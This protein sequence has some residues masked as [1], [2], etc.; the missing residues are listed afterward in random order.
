MISF[1][2]F[3]LFYNFSV[4]SKCS[5]NSWHSRQEGWQ[6][7]TFSQ[8]HFI[9]YI[10]MSMIYILC[11]MRK[12]K[13]SIIPPLAFF[14]SI[15]RKCK[16]NK[17]KKKPLNEWVWSEVSQSSVLFAHQ[18][19]KYIGLTVQSAAASQP[20][21]VIWSKTG[22]TWA[23]GIFCEFYLIIISS[24]KRDIPEQ[25]TW[26]YVLRFPFG[27]TS[28]PKASS[29]VGRLLRLLP[30]LHHPCRLLPNLGLS[31]LRFDFCW[32]VLQI[33]DSCHIFSSLNFI[34]LWTYFEQDLDHIPPFVLWAVPHRQISVFP[35]TQKSPRARGYQGNAGQ[36]WN[37][38]FGGGGLLQIK[39]FL[40][41]QHNAIVFSSS[42]VFCFVHQQHFVSI[43]SSILFPSTLFSHQHT[44]PQMSSWYCL[45]S[46]IRRIQ[47][48]TP[49][50]YGP[51]A[52]TNS[53]AG[54]AVWVTKVCFSLPL[55]PHTN[56]KK[57]GKLDLLYWWFRE[58][59]F[60]RNEAQT[61]ISQVFSMDLL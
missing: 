20:V 8:V 47:W 45:Y 2:P 13:W 33:L 16:N 55:G 17:P 29:F 11:L 41:Y 57:I 32:I 43:I 36:T 28:C 14:V 37:T 31:K 18:V 3:A 46:F 24:V 53:L 39:G 12:V 4:C 61:L 54:S 30:A 60:W 35:G 23:V 15:Y 51:G 22:S 7:Y 19:K 25:R 48:D 27:P 59:I 50:W 44:F 5:Q 1:A 40:F 52:H 38:K 21:K 42:T 56:S 49:S 34:A 6:G 26:F 58:V 10:N 9:T